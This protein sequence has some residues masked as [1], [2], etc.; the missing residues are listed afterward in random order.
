L[1]LPNHTTLYTGVDA[2]THIWSA[3]TL[4]G[5]SGLPMTEQS[6][7]NEPFITV[8]GADE[9]YSTSILFDITQYLGTGLQHGED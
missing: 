9:P 8:T 1:L 4:S 3:E 7:E 6:I 2:I 5:L